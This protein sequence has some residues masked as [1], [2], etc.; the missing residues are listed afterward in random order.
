MVSRLAAALFLALILTGCD[1][2][3]SDPAG[4]EVTADDSMR[5]GRFF[6]GREIAGVRGHELAE[7]FERPDR[8]ESE[9]P[10]R[11]VRALELDS[12]D[13][14]ADIGAGTGYFTFRISPHVPRGRVLAVDIDEQ[15]LQLVRQRMVNEGVGNVE[16]VLSRV[17]DPALNDRSIDLALIVDSYHE[18]SHPQ[19]MLD[20]I[21]RG[22]REGG[23][24][25]IV[26]YRGEDE[27]V[28]VHPLHRMTE[29]QIRMEVEASGYEWVETRDFMPRQHVVVFRRPVRD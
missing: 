1:D 18:F 4:K 5:T 11:L 12:S 20:G 25:V 23:R 27:T 15:M 28:D 21:F 29:E 22:L 16:P 2:R 9:L 10:D 17:D 24:L 19:E 14:V 13:V 3:S 26:E 6:M 8:E 7:W